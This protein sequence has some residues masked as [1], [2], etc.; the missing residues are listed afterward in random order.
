MQSAK[1]TF[2]ITLRDRLAALDPARTIFL[3]G[4]TRPAIV[5]AENAPV[6]AAPPLPE[7]FYLAWEAAERLSAAAGAK[8][9]LLKLGCTVS[10]R[11]AGSDGS[12]GVDRGRALA[13]LDLELARICAPHFAAKQD[14]TQTPAS[15]LGSAVLWTA[16]AYDAPEA[17][18]SELHRAAR[19]DVFFWPEVDL[20]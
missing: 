14:H 3:D 20:P 18:G 9:P 12:N 19:V 4:A 2:Y 17:A 11:T 1:D 10:Y 13:A 8:R 7:V 16:P 15:D 6:T 5:V